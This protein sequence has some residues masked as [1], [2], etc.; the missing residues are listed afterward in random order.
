MSRRSHQLRQSERLRKLRR[1]SED[2]SIQLRAQGIIGPNHGGT[3]RSAGFESHPATVPQSSPSSPYFFPQEPLYALPSD[4]YDSQSINYAQYP[5][6]TQQNG[7]ARGTPE[8]QDVPDLHFGPLRGN[9]FYDESGIESGSEP[10]TP[11]SAFDYNDSP[12]GG[13]LW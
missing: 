1:D 2:H 11:A 13:D 7:S 3:S 10:Q 6:P 4:I 12:Y 5:T 8:A 9:L